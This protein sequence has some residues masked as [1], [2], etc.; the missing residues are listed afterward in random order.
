[1]PR[2]RNHQHHHPHDYNRED[3]FKWPI[4][5]GRGVVYPKGYIPPNY[6][7][8]KEP[9][10]LPAPPLWGVVLYFALIFGAV[11]LVISQIVR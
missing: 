3:T 10:T 4:P 7:C 5:L 8:H 2:R 11:V 1:M 6:S 9:Y